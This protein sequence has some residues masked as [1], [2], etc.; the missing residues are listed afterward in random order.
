MNPGKFFRELQRRNVYRAAVGYA[1]VAWLIIQ[2]V[3]QVAPAFEIP[4]WVIRFVIVLLAIGAPFALVLAWAFE[5]TPEG[6]VRTEDVPV[7]TSRGRSFG[8]ILNFSIIGVLA[9]AVAGLLFDRLRPDRRRSSGAAEKSIA[10]LP[11]ENMS[12]DPEN[13]FFADGIQ[14]DILTSLAE[15]AELKVI[16]RT[17]TLP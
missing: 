15:I 8:R 2:V 16:S 10:V 11:F 4:S 17:S 3:T 5:L 12:N 13:A 7:E 6:L 14:D 9:L 1:A